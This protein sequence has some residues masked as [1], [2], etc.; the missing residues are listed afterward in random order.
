V[1]TFDRSPLGRDRGWVC[2]AHAARSRYRLPA[3]YP[4]R[5]FAH[6]GGLAS[7]GNDLRDSY[8]QAEIYVDRILRGDRPADALNLSVPQSV[9][10]RVDE[11]I[12]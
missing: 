4:F 11:V 10:V 7:Y 2:N 1:V 12:E 5:S 9:L 8:R 3:I 6:A